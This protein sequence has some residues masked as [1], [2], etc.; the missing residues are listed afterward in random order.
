MWS[1]TALDTEHS[2]YGCLE[3]RYLVGDAVVKSEIWPTW[4]SESLGVG[5]T[6]PSPVPNWVDEILKAGALAKDSATLAESWA[7]GG[8]GTRP[9]EDENNAKYWAEQ[10]SKGG[11][12]GGIG[13]KIG[14]GLKVMNQDTLEVDAVSNFD[15]DNTLPITAAAVQETVGNIEVLLGTI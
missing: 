10:A 9:G 11:G 2:G 6:P 14:H 13:Y 5:S 7:I 4:V 8:T 1:V 3:L 15:G 12:G